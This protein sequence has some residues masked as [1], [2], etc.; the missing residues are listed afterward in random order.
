MRIRYW[1]VM[2]QAKK[3]YDRAL[4]PACQK[5]SLTHNELDVLLFLHNNPGLDRAADIVSHRGMAKSHVS[6][7]VTRL[8]RRGLLSRR[9]DSADRRTVHLELAPSALAIAEEG[10]QIQQSFFHRIFQGMTPEEL[11]MWQVIIEKVCRNIE[12]L[13]ESLC[14]TSG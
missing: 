12:N 9:A 11:A 8:G 4:E 14:Q 5:W 10:R 7:S 6:L 13:E 1:D 3:E 2:L